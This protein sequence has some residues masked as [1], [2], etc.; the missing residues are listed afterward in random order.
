MR[1]LVSFVNRKIKHSFLAT[2][3]FW[4]L[5][6]KHLNGIMSDIGIIIVLQIEQ[7][8]YILQSVFQFM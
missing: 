6:L 8:T 3:T 2:D 5:L 1:K 7:V 4:L